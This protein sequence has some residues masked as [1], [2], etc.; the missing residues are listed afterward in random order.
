[1]RRK[2]L[3]LF[4]TILLCFSTPVFAQTGPI[5]PAR[6]I[7]WSQAGIPGGIPERTTICAT[8]SP[9]ATHTDINNA[10]ASCP[11]GQVVFLNEGTYNLSG[12]IDFR[13]RPN[14]TL[15]GAGADKTILI[16]N[17]TTLQRPVLIENA[18]PNNPNLPGNVAN[19]TA[20]Y[21]KGT[22]VIILDNTT[23][24]QIGSM[25]TLDQLDDCG[26]SGT[27]NAD[28]GEIWVCRRQ[29]TCS[30]QTDTFVGRTNR[31]QVQ[32]VIVTAINGNNVTIET[33][34]YMPNWRAS[35]SPGA[36]W[37]S[38]VPITGV[39]IED[40]A[41]DHRP[42]PAM[43]TI[44]L[45]NAYKCWVKGVK[46]LTPVR[47]HIWLYI[48]N[49]NV[50]RDSYF[51]GT[52]SAASTSY[53]I[54]TYLASDN[55][56][57]NNIFQHITTPMMLGG[58]ATGNVYGYNFAI[59]DFYNV[60][61]SW[62]QASQ[63]HHNPGVSFT[64]FEGQDGIGFTADLVWGTS[65][66]AT[67][68][69]NRLVGQEPGKTLQTVPIYIYAFS[70]FHNVIGSVLG[71]K[72]YHT[73]YH[74]IPPTGPNEYNMIY[75]LGWAGHAGNSPSLPNDLRVAETLMRWGNYDVVTDTVRFE[76]SEVPLGDS[77]YPNPV[78]PDQTLPNSYYLSAKP[79]W[80]DTAF[81]SVPYPPIGPD[82][83]GGNVLD[84][85]GHAYKIPA[86]LCYENT[87]LSGDGTT[88]AFNADTCYGN[89]SPRPDPATNLK[90]VVR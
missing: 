65:H 88:L 15:R 9:G 72:G 69:R 83:T 70:R 48:S 55:L 79:L 6:K 23:N 77:F 42:N 32:N 2:K 45:Q 63:Y 51:Y 49:N 14:R 44:Y 64:L 3:L 62:Q 17:A 31:A 58:G 57:E 11:A 66:F 89:T 81:G 39:G 12:S 80:F 74:S 67:V 30:T 43:S 29:G 87:P 60:V 61:P 26:S 34:L 37:S 21:A 84:V 59:D 53:G 85:G 16:F 86:R 8:L 19:W 1:M 76:A 71:K 50:I 73:T 46:S 40:M 78:P 5:D 24:L 56:I 13:D 25:I 38:A 82:V 90:V 75:S 68:F 35:Q 52:Q 27:C 41:L 33:G 7:D 18:A 22:T 47:N 10:I 20:G 54:E 36:W 28:N 4:F